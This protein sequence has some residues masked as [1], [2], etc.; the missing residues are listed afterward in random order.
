[1]TGKLRALSD[2]DAVENNGEVFAMVDITVLPSGD[3]PRTPP[4]PVS[5]RYNSARRIHG[6]HW[7]PS[8][9]EDHG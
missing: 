9:L 2:I 1:M 7:K 4:L 8:A 5:S 6:R 3:V